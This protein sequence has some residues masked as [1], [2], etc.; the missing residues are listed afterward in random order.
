[1]SAE[2]EFETN[3]IIR[4]ASEKFQI[5]KI[6]LFGSHANGSADEESDI[7]LC[8]I[9]SD[10]RRK[11]DILRDLRKALIGKIHHS[12]DILV[13]SPLDFAERATSMNSIERDILTQGIMIYG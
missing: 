11:I 1:M 13:Y 7:D 6:Y 12:L 9:S 8:I 10:P 4:E 2:I 3:I 5:E